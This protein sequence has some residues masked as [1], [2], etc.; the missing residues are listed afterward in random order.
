[1]RRYFIG[2]V[3]LTLLL[4]VVSFVMVW[5]PSCKAYY[6]VVLSALP[7]Y[8]AVVTGLMHYAVVKS[9]HK[10][11]RTFVKNFLGITIGS[12]FLHLAVLCIWTL[13]HLKGA[14]VFIVAFCVGYVLYLLYET[15]SLVLLVRRQQK[16]QTPAA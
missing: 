9:L 1:M 13:T 8:F 5:C 15:V 7:L 4:V 3:S 6:Q 11:P 14:K 2:L 10:A 12:L 16:Q